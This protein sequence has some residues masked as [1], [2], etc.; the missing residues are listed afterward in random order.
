[1]TIVICYEV[2]KMLVVEHVSLKMLF[3]TRFNI[4]NLIDHNYYH[5]MDLTKFE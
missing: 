4:Y 2:F 5:T 3:G 1:M